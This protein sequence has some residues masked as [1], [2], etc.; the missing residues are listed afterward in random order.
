MHSL[1]D[2][3]FQFCWSNGQELCLFIKKKK[4]WLVYTGNW[5]KT[6][7]NTTPTCLVYKGNQTRKTNTTQVLRKNHTT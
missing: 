7:T 2:M 1:D 4:K 3:E 6:I 5:L